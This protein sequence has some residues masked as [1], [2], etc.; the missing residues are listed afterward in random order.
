[1]SERGFLELIARRTGVRCKIDFHKSKKIIEQEL[2][3]VV[4]YCIYNSDVLSII[5]DNLAEPMLVI[6]TN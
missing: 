5:C 6:R 3:L 2:T 4:G 1:M